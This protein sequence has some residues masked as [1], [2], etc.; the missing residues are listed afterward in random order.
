MRVRSVNGTVFVKIRTLNSLACVWSRSTSMASLLSAW[1]CLVC[2]VV[3][4]V[5]PPVNN[6]DCRDI[7]GIY[8]ID[9]PADSTM[10]WALLLNSLGLGAQASQ[11]ASFQMLPGGSFIHVS[12]NCSG[13]VYLPDGESHE[14]EVV[15]DCWLFELFPRMI[16]KSQHF[17]AYELVYEDAEDGGT[18]SVYYSGSFIRKGDMYQISV[19]THTA[20]LLNAFAIQPNTPYSGPWFQEY[21]SDNSTQTR[22]RAKKNIRKLTK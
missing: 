8:L 20:R 11:E 2:A 16:E 9:R 4:A 6:L 19:A 21:C 15:S 1:I 10:D 12:T 14:Q 7:D 3:C 13:L 18:D 22:M 17:Y 5:A